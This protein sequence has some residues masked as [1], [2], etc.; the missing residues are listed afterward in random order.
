MFTRAREGSQ[1]LGSTKKRAKIRTLSK[2]TDD[3][4]NWLDPTVRGLTGDVARSVSLLSV[5][6]SFIDI[7]NEETNKNANADLIVGLCIVIFS[8]LR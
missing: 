7:I 2:L 5:Q 1:G 3:I 6:D 4:A 8:N